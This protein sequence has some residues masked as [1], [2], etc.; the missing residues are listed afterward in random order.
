MSHTSY[1]CLEKQTN[2]E[3]GNP[4]LPCTDVYELITDPISLPQKK[5]AAAHPGYCL[6]N[7][8]ICCMNIT[9]LGLI[10]YLYTQSFWYSGA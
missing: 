7:S 1:L 3:K 8:H 4:R 6:Q 5:N 2:K 10:L 9:I